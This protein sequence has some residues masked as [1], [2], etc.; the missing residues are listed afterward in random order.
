[1]RENTQNVIKSMKAKKKIIDSVKESKNAELLMENE[2]I[3]RCFAY[4]TFF[5]NSERK[6]KDPKKSIRATM[7]MR[8]YVLVKFGDFLKGNIKFW[9]G[10]YKFL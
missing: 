5:K 7:K 4:E 8:R 6:R 3:L 9:C 2:N 1:M 10:I